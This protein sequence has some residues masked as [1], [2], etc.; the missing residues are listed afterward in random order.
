[1]MRALEPLC[2]YPAA[3]GEPALELSG[4]LIC[5]RLGAAFDS[6]PPGSF[7]NHLYSA[8]DRN[9]E[10]ISRCNRNRRWRYHSWHL[11]A[12]RVQRARAQLAQARRGDGVALNH[13]IKFS[14]AGAKSDHEAACG[15]AAVNRNQV[16][17]DYAVAHLRR[18]S[19]TS[20]GGVHSHRIDIV[21]QILGD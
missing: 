16:A 14:G 20:Q 4:D 10:R 18:R 19:G 9:A 12:A 7:T 8:H 13:G 17:A 21:D 5:S 3:I 6:A 1:M 2:A 15:A 11:V